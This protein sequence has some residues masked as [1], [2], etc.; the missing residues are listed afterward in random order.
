MSYFKAKFNA[1]NSISAGD[2]PQTQLKKL[3]PHPLAGLKGAC[4]YEEVGEGKERGK[5]GKER[6]KVSYPLKRCP[7]MEV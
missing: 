2:P 7:H 3:P 6:G 1:S 5:G 4:F